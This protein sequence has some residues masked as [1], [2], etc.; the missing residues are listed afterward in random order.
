[1]RVNRARTAKENSS[2]SVMPTAKATTA[3]EKRTLAGTS[4]REDFAVTYMASAAPGRP[5][6]MIGK[7]PVMYWSVTP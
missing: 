5:N 7:E 3:L 1:M 4:Q 6:I 2:G